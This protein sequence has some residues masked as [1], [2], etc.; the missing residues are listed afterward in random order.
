[1][2]N[3]N[4]STNGVCDNLTARVLH[5]SSVCLMC[6]RT[7]VK[8]T[9]SAASRDT[10]STFGTMHNHTVPKIAPGASVA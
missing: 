9:A 4:M 7:G 8:L 10:L 1:M 6:T 3:L 5:L 2:L